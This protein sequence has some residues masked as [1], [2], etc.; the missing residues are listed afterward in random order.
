[1]SKLELLS[2]ALDYIEIN[3]YEDITADDVAKECYCSK[4][5]LQK[6][7]WRLLSYYLSASAITS[8]VWSKYFAPDRL[9]PIIK[10]NK[11]ILYWFND[12]KSVHPVWYRSEY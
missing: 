9:Q 8:I 2:D 4:S 5:Y 3:I 7:F 12:M 6:I 10:L 1:M 11:D